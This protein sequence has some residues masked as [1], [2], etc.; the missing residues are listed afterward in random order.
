MIALNYVLHH[1]EGLE[2]V[3]TSSPLLSQLP[4]PPALILIAKIFSSLLPRLPMK[5]ELDATAL[6]HDTAVVEGYVN[7]PLVHGRGTPRMATELMA[8]IDWTQAHAAELAL[9]SLVVHGGDDRIAGPEAS[10]TFFDN[11]TFADKERIEYDGY[12]HEVFNELGKEQV[13][14]DVEA[15]LAHHL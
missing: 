11:V 7:D 4:I 13:L 1:P 2:G 5:N 6:S 8:A 12:Y 10:Q 15:W 14:A 9:P 3:V